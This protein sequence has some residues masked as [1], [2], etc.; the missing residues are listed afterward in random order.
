MKLYNLNAKM[1]CNNRLTLSGS[2]YFYIYGRPGYS[3]LFMGAMMKH[4]DFPLLAV[5]SCF[6]IHALKR[7]R[8]IFKPKLP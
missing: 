5:L 2:I 8:P 6:I 1:Y 3:R 7:K 4:V